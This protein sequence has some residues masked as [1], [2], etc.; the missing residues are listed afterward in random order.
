MCNN[1]KVMEYERVKSSVFLG[2]RISENYAEHQ[3]IEVRLVKRDKFIA[4]Q[5]KSSDRAVCQEK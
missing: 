5:K 2:V 4:G 3:E 1:T